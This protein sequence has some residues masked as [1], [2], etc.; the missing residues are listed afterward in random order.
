ME[1]ARRNEFEYFQSR[2]VWRTVSF[3]EDWKGSVCPPVDVNKG[4]DEHFETR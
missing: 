3:Q 1:A 4:D 2:G